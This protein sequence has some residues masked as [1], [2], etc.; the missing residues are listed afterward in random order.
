MIIQ[1]HLWKASEGWYP[2]LLKEN[3][4]DAQLIIVFGS[5]LLLGNRMLIEEIKKTYPAAILFG[6]STAGAI[7]GARV[8]DDTLTATAIH[9][10]HTRLC[11]ASEMIKNADQRGPMP[12]S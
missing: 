10:E 7:L 6:S 3:P 4:R 2:G 11:F 5:S 9:W 12:G 1:Q 8:F